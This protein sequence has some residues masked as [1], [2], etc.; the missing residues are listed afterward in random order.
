MAGTVRGRGPGIQQTLN[1]APTGLS[2]QRALSTEKVR[3][4]GLV[5]AGRRSGLPGRGAG[6]QGEAPSAP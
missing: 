1:A 5:E 6:G 4:P 3:V 2:S